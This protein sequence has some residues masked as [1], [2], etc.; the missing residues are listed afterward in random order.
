MYSRPTAETGSVERLSRRFM[1]E[2]ERKR[3]QYI[4]CKSEKIALV[5][6]KAEGKDYKFFGARE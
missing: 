2:F 6:K 3:H 4:H 5:K 1:T